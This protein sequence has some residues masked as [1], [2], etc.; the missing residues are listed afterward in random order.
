MAVRDLHRLEQVIETLRAALEAL[1]VVAPS[2]LAGL[3]LPE[4][5]NRYGQ[6][7]DDW[8]LPKAEQARLERAIAVGRDG[9]VLVE[10]VYGPDAPAGL[11]GVEAV[12]VLRATWIQQFYLDDGQVC[13]RDKHSG[14]PPGSRMILNPYDLDARPGVKRGRN[15]RGYK[16]HF[17]ETC[18]PNQPHLITYVAT[19]D[20][21]TADLDTVPDRHADLAA[22]DLLPEVHLVDAGYVSVGQILT[23]ADDMA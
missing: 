13:W 17:T 7:G 21:A 5:T 16:A 10:A 22:R 20:A 18:E 23:A 3:V 8:R 15:W 2:W 9:L 14:L 12:Q 4:W 11:A 1:A 6:R 19:T